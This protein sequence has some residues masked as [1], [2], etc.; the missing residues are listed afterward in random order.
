M[1]PDIPSRIDTRGHLYR[2]LVGSTLLFF[3]IGAVFLWF[4]FKALENTEVERIHAETHGRFEELLK[5]RVRYYHYFAE[6]LRNDTATLKN[7]HDGNTKA[8]FKTSYY[9]R[10][11]AMHGSEIID[12]TVYTEAQLP[13]R[14]DAFKA[15][16]G[17]GGFFDGTSY[18]IFIPVRYGLNSPLTLSIQLDTRRL[19]T[20]LTSYTE[21]HTTTLYETLPNYLTTPQHPDHHHATFF[22]PL[23]N[24]HGDTTATAVFE[25]DISSL[26]RSVERRFHAASAILLAGLLLLALFLGRSLE[27]LTRNLTRSNHI[28]AEERALFDMGPTIIFKWRNDLG[29]PVEFVSTNVITLFGY[30]NEA[31]YDRSI[32]YRDLIYHG[33][34]ERV[35]EEVRR[36][37]TSGVS[38]FRHEPYRVLSKSGSLH[39]IE[40]FTSIIRNDAGEITHYHG[41]LID[42]TRTKNVE[43]DLIERNTYIS[44]L[45]DLLSDIV[46]ITDTYRILEVNQ[47]FFT[48]FDEF[49][50][51]E[52]FHEEYRCLCELFVEKEGFLA[53]QGE[54]NWIDYLMHTAEQQHHCLVEYRGKQTPFLIRT[55][56][57]PESDAKYMITLT[58]LPYM[59][60][61]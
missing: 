27:R 35:E 16:L 15:A 21:L 41:Y 19:L 49:T 54:G 30:E 57:L 32:L 53:S 36:F 11:K 23:L 13:R 24:A 34:V 55:A 9:E 7:L 43:K 20:H 48:F 46:I 39:W 44:T 59:I 60:R 18:R 56:R 33:D 40:D 31:F 17:R 6:L 14:F 28:L 47:A 12:F 10:L 3:I 26:H 2:Y 52:A 42:I 29:W 51:I 22:V 38:H 58:K 4:W 61:L 5:E 25:Y 50:S 8:L 37:S 45:F 1:T